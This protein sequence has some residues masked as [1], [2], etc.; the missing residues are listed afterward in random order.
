MRLLDKLTVNGGWWT[1]L[2][3]GSGEMEDYD[4]LDYGSPDWTHYS[5]S[6]VDVTEGYIFDLNV[7]W[8]LW[9]QKDMTVRAQAGYKQTGWTWKTAACICS[10]R[11]TATCRRTWAATT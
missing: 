4:W 2:T 10:I 11:N 9:S 8:D 3:E 5:L 6:E 1:A 7:A